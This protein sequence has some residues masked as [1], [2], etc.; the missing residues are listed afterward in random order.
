MP[1]KA[2][3]EEAVLD[4]SP[5]QQN[6]IKMRYTWLRNAGWT[7][8]NATLIAE[9]LDINWHLAYDMRKQCKDETLLLKVLF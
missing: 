6:V 3:A 7:D 8:K 9:S 1:S 5:E 4:S 2:K